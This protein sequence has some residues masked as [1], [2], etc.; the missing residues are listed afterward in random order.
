MTQDLKGFLE[1]LTLPKRVEY[2]EDLLISQI[3][4]NEKMVSR[5]VKDAQNISG[6]ISLVTQI[7]GILQQQRGKDRG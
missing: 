5:L 4:L 2:L 7:T 3:D 1:T 6:L